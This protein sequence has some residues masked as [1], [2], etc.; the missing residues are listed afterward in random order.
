M[1]LDEIFITIESKINKLLYNGDINYIDFYTYLYDNSIKIQQIKSP[2]I[3][4]DTIEFYYSVYNKI[5]KSINGY[6]VNIYE[7]IIS[8]NSILQT[9]SIELNLFNDNL[10]LINNL[11][12]YFNNE[13]SKIDP[14]YIKQDFVVY[15][16]NK[17]YE[18]ITLKLFT[19]IN[20]KIKQNL[21][22]S[23]N[24]IE[25]EEEE[26]YYI[27][28]LIE[29]INYCYSNK[30]IES[31]IFEINIITNIYIYLEES[32]YKYSEIYKNNPIFLTY[33]NNINNFY[34]RQLSVLN[35]EE[36]QIKYKK[37]FNEKIVHKYEYIIK[38]TLNNLLYSININT[39]KLDYC[40]DINIIIKL[41]EC[42][43]YCYNNEFIQSTLNKWIDSYFVNDFAYILDLIYLT[44]LLYIKLEE[45]G[46]S[47]K[48][49]NIYNCTLYL[50]KKY[51]PND[52]SVIEK[53]DKYIREYLYKE[54]NIPLELFYNSLALYF[55]NYIDDDILFA[56]YKAFL[57]KRLNRYNFN[58]NYI[59]IEIDIIEE[60]VY[61]LNT[62]N[63]YKIN[64]IKKDLIASK[65]YSQEFNTIYNRQ[66]KLII[67][68]DGIW[69]IKPKTYN[70]YNT[71][72]NTSLNKFT[73]DF[74]TFYNCKYQNKKLDWNYDASSCILNYYIN[75]DKSIYIDCPLKYGNILYEF[76]DNN[77]YTPINKDINIYCNE[78]VK[79]GILTLNNGKYI[80]NNNI[81]YKDITIKHT[82]SKLKVIKKSQ[83]REIV[84]SQKELAE[85]FIIRS[86][87]HVNSMNESK[88][89]EI[90]KN[91]FNIIE[92]LI[93]KILDKLV[94]NQYLIKE[95]TN[96]LYII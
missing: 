42:L 17:W 82:N 84:F 59:E 11:I 90:I 69:N 96:Y 25:V 54:K 56:Y 3:R 32:L 7:K 71:Y 34:N 41:N 10:E 55:T 75:E 44:N 2:S 79:Y 12:K 23:I 73:L 61:K 72:F 5:K 51:L 29:H 95:E 64:I 92:S 20:K 52:K 19:Y 9:Y 68:T 74:S 22:Y 85:L 38:K 30:I 89:I 8:N 39:F 86:V 63:L 35:L 67:T 26:L 88:L 60:L 93:H 76:N 70:F 46:K 6:I 49:E 21:N 77:S 43:N 1:E 48:L 14:N 13:L 94:Y 16:M 36:L 87:K 57:I 37:L 91:K 31:N 53:Y 28:E 62:P 66:S 80:L 78:L 40:F 4:I 50:Y 18:N 47:T 24:S 33:I 15:G 81:K 27:N 45:T 65:Y 58:N 83:K